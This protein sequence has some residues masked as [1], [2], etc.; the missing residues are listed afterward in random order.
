MKI[1]FT[2]GGTAGH[3][4]PALA[5]AGYIKSQQP[6][7]DI[8][9][10][11][12]EGAIEERLVKRAGYPLYTFPL[13]GLSR[14]L[15]WKGIRQN[16]D[17]LSKAAKASRRA[18]EIL[19]EFQPDLVLGT[20]GY[21]S[22]PA[23][24]AAVRQGIRCAMLEV[25]AAPGM[26]VKRMSRKVDCVFTSF[27]ETGPQLPGAKKV[28]LTGSPVRQEIVNARPDGLKQRLFGE[29]GGPMVVS[30]WGSVGALY[31]N[32]KMSECIKLC[33]QEKP[34]CLVHAAGASNYKWMPEYIAKMGVDL[35]TARNIDLREYIFDMD[36]VLCEADL[37][38]CRAGASTLAEVCAAGKPSIIVPSPYVAD[39]HQEKNARVLERYGAAVVITEAEATGKKIYDTACQLLQD[40]AKL[41]EMGAKARSLAKTDAVE[42]IYQGICQLLA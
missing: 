5:V 14:K 35:E 1:L 27:A 17:A 6:Q 41:Q 32:Q 26:V 39:N 12:A 20:G 19:G 38:I 15:N 10:A 9:F 21:A 24:Q 25:N 3:G 16:V 4:N 33:A 7:A 37:V 34:F 40:P 36:K 31:M 13:A 42:Q 18:R 28:V 22:Y 23:V 8:R 2:G 29:E 11:G 30:F